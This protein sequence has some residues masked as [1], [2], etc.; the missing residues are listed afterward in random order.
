M[1]RN[2]IKAHQILKPGGISKQKSA[3]RKKKTN[4]D[5]TL[6]EESFQWRKWT[7]TISASMKPARDDEI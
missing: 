7:H 4:E 3:Y 6:N 5:R 1:D 2:N